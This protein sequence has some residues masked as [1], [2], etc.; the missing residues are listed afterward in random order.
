MV[1][2][3]L[4]V[5]QPAFLR[6]LHILHNCALHHSL[7]R[8]CRRMSWAAALAVSIILFILSLFYLRGLR[9]L[10]SAVRPADSS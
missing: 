8:D 4:F 6:M 1:Q 10:C 9:H 7:V 2:I 5:Q 3:R